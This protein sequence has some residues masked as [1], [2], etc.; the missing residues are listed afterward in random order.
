MVLQKNLV[1]RKRLCDKQGHQRV[2]P[3][4]E[5][6]CEKYDGDVHF[7]TLHVSGLS[8]GA[9]TRAMRLLSTY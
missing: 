8:H 1:W 4:A 3:Q 5:G 7:G 2:N 9:A 6:T